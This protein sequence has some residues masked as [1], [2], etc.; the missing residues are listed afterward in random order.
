MPVCVDPELFTLHLV[1]QR[2]EHSWKLLVISNV[3]HFLSTVS[4]ERSNGHK[5]R[6][7]ACVLVSTARRNLPPLTSPQIRRG[8]LTPDFAVES[9]LP[10]WRESARISSE[11]A[12]PSVVDPA[13]HSFIRH[14]Y[15]INQPGCYKV[16]LIHCRLTNKSLGITIGEQIVS[17]LPCTSRHWR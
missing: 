12:R 6:I 13:I 9:S 8:N 4:D 16:V 17:F 2:A 7:Q 3:F 11:I 14:I 1:I 15:Y 5:R 10:P